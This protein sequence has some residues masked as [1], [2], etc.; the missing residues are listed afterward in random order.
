MTG[1][2]FQDQKI[3]VISLS[4]PVMERIEAKPPKIFV[5]ISLTPPSV[6]VFPATSWIFPAILDT[7]CNKA[8]DID[9]NH[10]LT[11][12]NVTDKEDFAFLRRKSG[13]RP[14]DVR[15]ANIWLH[16]NPYNGP[17]F[18]GP[19]WP[20][21]LKNSD[22]IRVMDKIK[23]G[24]AVPRFPLLGL[25]SLTDNGLVLEVDGVSSNFTIAQ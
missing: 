17:K 25:E 12:T 4:N 23:V 20:V 11:W 24:M 16:L 8:F 5:G 18:N 10:L 22:E 19:L 1:S 13:N 2:I 3:E 6:K 15:A 9:E 7:G 21:W 14:H